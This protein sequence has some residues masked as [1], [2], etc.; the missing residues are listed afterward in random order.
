[1]LTIA[2]I[3]IKELSKTK[4]RLS[5]YI[6]ASEREIL[7]LNMLRKVIRAASGVVSQVWVMGTDMVAKTAALDEGAEWIEDM[8]MDVN[9]S[10][11]LAFRSVWK[12]NKGA[13]Y[14]AG[15]LPFLTQQD[16]N[17]LI[18]SSS[19][20]GN[21]VISPARYSGGTNALLLPK[22]SSFKMLLGPWS[23][24]RHLAQ[25]RH[26]N[27]AFSIHY[28]QGIGFDL[29]TGDDLKVYSKMDPILLYNLQKGES[30]E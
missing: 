12:I 26:L 15:D 6:D 22:P 28:T 10:L 18:Q 21:N 9:Q 11:N 13:L 24:H 14:L 3:P 7:A 19:Q 4:S 16:L 29:D 5:P 25:A 20:S 27:L 1:M 23:F 17:G 8:G 30:L 2:I